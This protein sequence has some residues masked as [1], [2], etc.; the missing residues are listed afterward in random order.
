MGR[1][2]RRRRTGK[3]VYSENRPKKGVSSSHTQPW[4]VFG[5]LESWTRDPA[6]HSHRCTPHLKRVLVWGLI[7]PQP[8]NPNPSRQ[9]WRIQATPDHFWQSRPV[10]SPGD[11]CALHGGLQT[12][13]DSPGEQHRRFGDWDDGPAPG[14]LSSARRGMCQDCLGTKDVESIYKK[15]ERKK[16]K[17]SPKQNRGFTK[18][19]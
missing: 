7:A 15:K 5:L 4:D 18:G 3:D 2:G 17:I 19:L 14:T 9:E 1:E 16:K 6:P 8:Q 13:G 10:G 12:P 11:G